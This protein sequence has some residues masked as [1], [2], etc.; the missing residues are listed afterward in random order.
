[1][2]REHRLALTGNVVL[3]ELDG[4]PVGI[5]QSLTVTDNYALEPIS[6]IGNINPLE[7]VPTRASHSL[8]MSQVMLY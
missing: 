8:R 7:H 1:M 6:G 3:V 2:A 4:K 5:C